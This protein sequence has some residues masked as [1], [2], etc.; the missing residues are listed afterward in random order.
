MAGCT[1]DMARLQPGP[2]VTRD[3]QT[4]SA[5]GTSPVAN[6]A[7][8]SNSTREGG[9]AETLV[10]L[11]DAIAAGEV[12]SVPALDVGPEDNAATMGGTG[13]AGGFAGAGTGGLAG[14]GGMGASGGTIANGGGAGGSTTAVGTG[15]AGAVSGTGG[16]SVDPDLVLW[17]P[18]DESSGTVAMDSAK[19]S[20][21]P[22]NAT[23]ATLGYGG[24]ATFSTTARVGSHALSLSPPFWTNPSTNG[25]YAA[26]PSLRNLAPEAVTIAVWVYLSAAS[27]AQN[28]ERVFDFSA[29]G[30]SFYL[31]TRVGSGAPLGTP[32][33][34]SIYTPLR[35]EQRLQ[36]AATLDARVW[37]HLA[38]V[39]PAGTPYTGIL[40]I[41]GVAAAT[42]N[43]MTLHPADLGTTT[44][45]WLGRSQS[46]ADPLF[47]GLLDDFR[48]YRRALS[49]QEIVAL[50]AVR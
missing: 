16:I 2:S 47:N 18:F 15:G 40:Y 32:P 11:K 37:H 49:Q 39:L 10:Q 30:S 9:A 19:V 41:D 1:L 26:L 3:A 31:T 35:G 50:M 17:Y 8:V 22:S 28:W 36:A 46:I 5:D 48:I 25:G 43:A 45:N 14:A 20:S 24:G 44:N 23:L 29:N 33:R 7:G 38:V 13:G 12:N 6:D 42:N 21:T 27:T 4:A 34:F